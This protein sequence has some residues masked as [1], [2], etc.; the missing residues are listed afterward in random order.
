MRRQLI[1]ISFSFIIMIMLKNMYTFDLN[2]MEKE[3]ILS[4]YNEGDFVESMFHLLRGC[5]TK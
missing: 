1:W 3:D 5:R 2:D 4:L